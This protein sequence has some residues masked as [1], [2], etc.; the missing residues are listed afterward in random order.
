[1]CEKPL[2]LDIWM[3]QNGLSRNIT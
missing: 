2:T 1:V 3:A